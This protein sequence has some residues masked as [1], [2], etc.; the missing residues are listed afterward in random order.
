M[1]D[2]D[3]FQVP[4]REKEKEKT[5][6][7]GRRIFFQKNTENFCYVKIYAYLVDNHWRC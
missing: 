1:K 5:N 6:V 4:E 3:L 2:W 7:W